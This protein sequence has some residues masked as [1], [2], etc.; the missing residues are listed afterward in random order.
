M[1]GLDAGLDNIP[2]HRD[3][4]EGDLFLAEL[5]GELD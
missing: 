1:Y 5:M 3:I 4:K 2:V